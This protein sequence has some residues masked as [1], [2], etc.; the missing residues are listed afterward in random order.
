MTNYR[1][2][3]TPGATWFFTVNLAERNHNTL[4]VDKIEP[5]RQAFRYIKQRHSFHID[6]VVVMP[7]HLH[8]IW[9]LPEGD[10][11]FS[12]RWSLLKGQFSRSVEKGERVSVGRGRKRER[13]I[14]QRRFWA[15][16]ITDQEDF[17]RHVD[18]IHWNPVKHGRVKQVA[19]W[20]Y[21]SFHHYVRL[22]VYPSTWGYA[23]KF[24]FDAGE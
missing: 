2:I 8:C 11:D 15:H 10:F 13:G 21:S 7:D 18:Y 23:G 5:L 20:P 12:T 1:R 3:Y 16:L 19:D 17:N 24:D 4:L 22:G 9:T 14:W 6:A